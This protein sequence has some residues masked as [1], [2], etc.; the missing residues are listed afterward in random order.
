MQA[1]SER[2]G[3]PGVV[4]NVFFDNDFLCLAPFEAWRR[5]SEEQRIV[6]DRFLE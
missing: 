5:G 6:V 3:A 2:S 4:F 1:D